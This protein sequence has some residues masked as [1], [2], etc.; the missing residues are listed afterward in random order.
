M[1]EPP[2]KRPKPHDRDAEATLCWDKQEATNSILP[3]TPGGTEAEH[4]IWRRRL[5]ALDREAAVEIRPPHRA[6][7]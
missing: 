7:L 1:P 3:Q 6:E 5:A 4:R 2:V